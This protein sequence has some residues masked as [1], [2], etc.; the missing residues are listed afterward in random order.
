MSSNWPKM[1]PSFAPAYQVSGI[2]FMFSSTVWELTT[3]IRNTSGATVPTN[4][5]IYAGAAG[6]GD[7]RVRQCGRL[8]FS[9]RSEPDF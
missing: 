3:P 1:G 6:E 2:P 7:R 4:N 9:R 5:T 8:F